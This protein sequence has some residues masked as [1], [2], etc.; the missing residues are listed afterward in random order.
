MADIKKNSKWVT[1]RLL[2]L[3]TA[4]NNGLNTLITN[5]NIGN[6]VSSKAAEELLAPTEETTTASKS[7]NIGDVIIVE[8]K[9]ATV[10]DNIAKGSTIANGVNIVYNSWPLTKTMYYEEVLY[11]FTDMET[12][13]RTDS[14]PASLYES[15]FFHLNVTIQLNVSGSELS[16]TIHNAQLVVDQ[17]THTAYPM[18]VIFVGNEGDLYVFNFTPAEP[19]EKI[20]VDFC[21][22]GRPAITEETTTCEAT[23]NQYVVYQAVEF[24]NPYYAPYVT[25]ITVGYSEEGLPM[26][27][28]C[29][30]GWTP[31]YDGDY[32]TGV[33]VTLISGNG[34]PDTVMLDVRVRYYS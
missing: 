6:F 13:A 26:N 15:Y 16:G 31:V 8:H 7:Y 20:L 14:T 9:W 29:I 2:E 28:I 4:T 22:I 5:A 18:P 11:L 1:D 12:Y 25:S 10:I 27:P 24:E 30:S 21:K 19:N 34:D 32:L 17:A 3:G 33:Y 23:V